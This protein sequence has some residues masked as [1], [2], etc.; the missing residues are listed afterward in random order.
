MKK[1][2]EVL[3]IV[4]NSDREKQKNKRPRSP[5]PSADSSGETSTSDQAK[6]DDKYISPTDIARIFKNK[7]DT[8]TLC[9]LSAMSRGTPSQIRKLVPNVSVNQICK[10]CELWQQSEGRGTVRQPRKKSPKRSHRR[11]SRRRRSRAR[12]PAK[13]RHTKRRKKKAVD[14]KAKRRQKAQKSIFPVPTPKKSE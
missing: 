11:S 3:G 1:L 10:M 2:E 8:K 5:S 7:I 4:D 13:H 6:G 12:S 9:Q 14:T